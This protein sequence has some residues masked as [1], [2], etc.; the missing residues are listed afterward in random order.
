MHITSRLRSLLA[1]GVSA[2][3]LITASQ[4]LAQARPPAGN[5]PNV[6]SELVVTAQ[7]REESIQ[8][9][10]IAVSAFSGDSLKNQR[11]ETGQD[12][13]QAVPNVN[14]SRGNFGG[15]NFQIR[16]IGTKLVATSADAA[17]G[18]HE[19][20]VPL[21]ANTLADAEFYDVARVEV[22]R[23][24]QG[25]QFGRNTTGGLVNVITN[26]PS[27]VFGARISGDVGNY[28]TRRVNGMVNLPLPANFALRVAGAYL[29]RDGFYDNLVT[30]HDVDDR[31]LWSARATLAWAPSDRLHAYFMWERFRENDNRL[32]VGKQLCVKDP[33]PTTIGGVPTNTSPATST[34]NYFSQGCK[35]ASLRGPDALQEINSAVT[36]GGGLGVAS[37]LIN[38]D[39]Y[40]GKLQN[41]DLRKIESV[42][43]PLYRNDADVYQL[44]LTYHLT[45]ALELSYTGA[46][47]EN[48]GFTEADYNRAVP[49]GTLNPNV[50]G[51]LLT[52]SQG[53]FNDPQVGRRNQFTTID[54]SGGTSTQRSHELRVQSAFDGPVNFS[55]GVSD[56][57]FKTQTDYFVTSNTLTALSEFINLITPGCP[58]TGALNRPD[59]IYVDPSAIPD[60]SGGNY[61]DSRTGYQI[62]SQAAF[63]EVYWN[64]TDDLKLTTGLRY[65]VDRKRA[66]PY[67]PRLLTAGIGQAPLAIQ[68]VHFKE[69]T[70]RV[71]L[72]WSPD[73]SFTDKTLLYA[74]YARGYKGGGF[75][76]PQSPGQE[77]FPKT[78]EPEF[79]DAVEVGAKNTLLDGRLILNGTLFHYSYKGYQVSSIIQRTSVNVNIDAK[80]WGAELE[81]IW[82]PI[83]KLRFNTSLGFLHTELG[84]NQSLDL[85]NL[86]QG[87]PSLSVVRNGLSYAMCVAPVAQ[88][89]RLQQLVNAGVLPAAAVT[90]SL[91]APSLLPGVCNG[92][93][94]PGTPT[95]TALG[96]SVTPS[97]GVPARLEGNELPNS[98]HMTAALGAQYQWELDG[99]WQVTPRVDFYYQGKSYARI[100]N[101]INDR[102]ESYT[103]TN[104]SVLVAKP[105]WGLQVQFYVKNLTDE[106]VITDQYQTDDTSG[107]FT[108][109]FMTEPR[110]YGVS[111]TKEF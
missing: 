51:G 55:A 67:Q 100:F 90:G 21:T 111:I 79:I 60:G 31:D 92:G 4:A 47:S 103:N 40:A 98:P 71:N 94:A 89:A 73:L 42:F 57:K 109:I 33:G 6:I 27:D 34:Q 44:N 30:G 110:T 99:G 76:P 104:L 63:G 107:L 37:G 93:F 66:Q 102:L 18:I 77:L 32:R 22:L 25:T 48:E 20:N 83:P 82:E 74:S 75:N 23:G 70:G 9:V 7:R 52:D 14:F 91:F 15:Y 29:K 5:A 72:E 11:I 49:T 43:D 58:Q 10:P 28:A 61:F 106:T 95:A 54:F 84:N 62:S 1:L 3:A 88:L 59:C 101:A 53:Y 105:D 85:M 65:T 45:D 8:D 2:G 13:L 87:D 81:G 108:N 50:F 68:T 24:P 38:G 86:T 80:L 19:N 35:L 17:I 39:A 96:F 41:P 12:L 36:L 78:Y 64:I 46:Y 56:L 97:A 26:Q 16:G 69:T